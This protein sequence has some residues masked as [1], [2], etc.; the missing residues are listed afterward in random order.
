MKMAE[1]VTGDVCGTLKACDDTLRTAIKQIE[2]EQERECVASLPSTLQAP[3]AELIV[4]R[5]IPEDLKRIVKASDDIVA[6]FKA[7]EEL[8]AENNQDFAEP[9]ESLKQKVY[10]HA[11][12]L[13]EVE[14]FLNHFQRG[15]A[16]TVSDLR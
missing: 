7:S 15:D 1:V 14:Y 11:D 3:F 4:Q 12:A 2:H 6:Y 9:Y 5:N 16:G 8:I 10:A 13:P